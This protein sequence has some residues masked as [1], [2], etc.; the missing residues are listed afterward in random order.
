MWFLKT[1][2]DGFIELLSTINRK[3]FQYIKL[4]SL[5]LDPPEQ[6]E[7]YAI[8]ELDPFK[9]KSLP[10]MIITPSGQLID[11]LAWTSTYFPSYRPLT[12]YIRVVDWDTANEFR[13]ID[14]RMDLENLDEACVGIIIAEVLSSSPY[15]SSYMPIN[16]L[17]C[18]S[19]YSYC[20]SKA[21]VLGLSEEFISEILNRLL[22]ARKLTAQP[23][24]AI[25][26]D[27]LGLI[28]NIMIRIYSYD[29]FDTSNLFKNNIDSQL[30]K[31]QKSLFD[32][33]EEENSYFKKIFDACLD[34]K[35]SGDIKEDTWNRL[36]NNLLDYGVI[37]DQLGKSREKRVLFFEKMISG[38]ELE[39]I[40]NTNIK[41]FIC[42]Y[43]VSKINLGTMS[44]V[45]LLVPYMSKYASILLWYG[46]LSGLVPK[47]TLLSDYDGLGRRLIRD[48]LVREDIISRPHADISVDEIE[49]FS[50]SDN[51]IKNFL[52][53]SSN[54][55]EIEIAPCI[56]TVVRW[57]VIDKSLLTKSDI[58][59]NRN[60]YAD[61]I[62]ELVKTIKRSSELV[63]NA[64]KPCRPLLNK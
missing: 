8:W 38:Y 60:K 23:N 31:K 21:M 44:H 18:A 49:V 24:R 3:S 4:D 5:P 34:I 15:N 37:N 61:T 54:K 39:R 43:L 59:I 41:A 20:F 27:V 11:F 36:T 19:T 45:D 26:T 32:R 62:N 14:N 29:K 52:R 47:S 17:L 55:L 1:S 53:G 9:V 30:S 6:N 57:G 33:F 22:K 7:L 2:K 35:Q 16:P 56:N 58:K 50:T 46:M 48:L 42:A 64:F 51:P 63:N 40:T 10:S 13:L 28:W 25:D 12:A